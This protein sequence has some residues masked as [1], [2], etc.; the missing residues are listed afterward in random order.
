[1]GA[2]STVSPAA[3]LD[4]LEHAV[5][6]RAQ[7]ETGQADL[8]RAA[9]DVDSR[10]RAART[11]LLPEPLRSGLRELERVRLDQRRR[12]ATRLDP[13]HDPERVQELAHLLRRGPHHRDVTRSRIAEIVRPLSVCA[14]PATV[15]SG[16]LR[17]WH[18]SDTKRAKLSEGATKGTISP[19]HGRFDATARRRP[20]GIPARRAARVKSFHGKGDLLPFVAPS[21]SFARFV[22]LACHDLRTPARDGRRLRAHAR[23]VDDLG[24]PAARYVSMMRAASEQMGELLDALGIVTRIEAGRYTPALIEADTLEL[25]QAAAARLGRRPVRAARC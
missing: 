8:D 11:G 12:I 25:A 6:D 3:W 19:S 1:M 14:K 18:A 24:D 5:P 4:P 23:A 9:V 10:T 7:S 20:P 2:I 13:R 21:E 22:S 17:S 16:V 15:A